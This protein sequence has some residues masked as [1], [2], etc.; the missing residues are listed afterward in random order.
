MEKINYSEVVALGF[1][2]Y[3]MND[4]VAFDKNGWHDFI[5][6]LKCGKYWFVWEPSDHSVVLR[7]HRKSDIIG[8]LKINTLEELKVLVAFFK[9]EKNQIFIFPKVKKD[10]N[11]ALAC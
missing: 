6:E 9:S 2:R 11:S 10:F 7:K 1:E 8:T 5:M 3:D 4:S